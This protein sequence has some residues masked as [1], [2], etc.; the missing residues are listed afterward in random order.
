ME[1]RK[2]VNMLTMSKGLQSLYDQHVINLSQVKRITLFL[3]A[4]TDW[5]ISEEDPTHPTIKK[6][7][8]EK[9]INYIDLYLWLIDPILIK[10]LISVH[11]LARIWIE[12]KITEMDHEEASEVLSEWIDVYL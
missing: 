9:L 11:Q 1:L 4:Q 7:L 8:E 5:M 10:S 3:D 12:K 2:Q 6:E